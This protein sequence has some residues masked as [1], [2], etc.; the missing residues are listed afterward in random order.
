MGHLLN[1]DGTLMN[2][3]SM[4]KL[5]DEQEAVVRNFVMGYNVHDLGAGQLGMAA[6]LMDLGAHTVTAV[7]KTYSQRV[8]Y[9]PRPLITL[10]GEE[11]NEYVRHGHYVDVAFIC[12]PEV[13][14]TQGLERLVRD[15]RVTIYIGQNF[16]GSACGSRE[17]FEELMTHEV[18]ATVPHRWNTL[19]VYGQRRVLR[20]PLPEEYAAM[21]RGDR[22]PYDF[23][24][25]GDTDAH[26][27]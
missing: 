5:T 1:A 8:A 3:I 23:A 17:L 26:L 9:P 12:W 13:Y 6:K 11:F 27:P 18:L 24:T 19:I 4:G 2:F 22:P 21:H 7:D 15:A 10:V 20:K 25:Y 16:D 14:Q